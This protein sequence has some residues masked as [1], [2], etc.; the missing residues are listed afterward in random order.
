LDKFEALKYNPYVGFVK[1]ELYDSDFLR[2]KVSGRI[3]DFRYFQRITDIEEFKKI[4]NELEFF[5]NEVL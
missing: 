4:C 1:T 3:F 5:E 2:H